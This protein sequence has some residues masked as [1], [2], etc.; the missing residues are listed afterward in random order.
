[1]LGTDT[2]G[3]GRPNNRVILPA[4]TDDDNERVKSKGNKI[5]HI[6][7]IQPPVYWILCGK[8][9]SLNSPFPNQACI[10]LDIRPGIVILLTRLVKFTTI[11]AYRIA[12]STLT[13]IKIIIP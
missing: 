5:I 9:H 2:K 6:H 13:C 12:C 4:R 3:H 8:V 7:N 1:M 11:V 10:K